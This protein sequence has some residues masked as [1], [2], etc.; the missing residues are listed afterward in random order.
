[1]KRAPD[2]ACIP[3]T[4]GKPALSARHLIDE[5]GA[6]DLAGLFKM[7][8]NETRLRLLHAVH[9]AG[10]L[11]VTD[12]AGKLEMTP[13]AISNQLQRLADRQVVVAR[14]DGNRLFYRIADP[15]IPGLLDLGMCLLEE[16]KKTKRRK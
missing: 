1:M 12:V 2:A 5:H 6:R 14:R 11:C 7:L 15:C 3:S 10:E 9:R 13:Q 16:T 4:V 8:A